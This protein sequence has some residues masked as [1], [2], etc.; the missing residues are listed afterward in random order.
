MLGDEPDRADD[1]ARR[2]VAA[3][4]RVLATN[5]A[6]TGWSASPV[7][8]PSMVV[9]FEPSAATASIKQAFT[10]RPSTSTVHAPH[11]P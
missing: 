9:I 1:L 3:L 2:A 6:C 8:S 11:C 4:E 7:A 10:R 5:A